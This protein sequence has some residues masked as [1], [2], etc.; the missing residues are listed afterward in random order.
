MRHVADLLAD[1]V[2]LACSKNGDLAAG[3]LVQSRESAQQGSLAGAIITKNGVKFTARKL[4]GDAAQGGKAA[5]L[6]DQVRDC[7]DVDGDERGFSQ[8]S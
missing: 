7:N 5:E 8:R 1:V 2:K 6:F 3:R 4:R